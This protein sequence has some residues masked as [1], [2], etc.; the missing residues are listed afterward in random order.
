MRY[1][2]FI[3]DVICLKL[4]D[5]LRVFHRLQRSRYDLNLGDVSVTFVKRSEHR[6][7]IVDIRHGKHYHMIIRFCIV[8]TER[9][10]E[11]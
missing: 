6:R 10:T 1:S 5:K 2:R 7:E 4:D 11:L 9:S 8:N 3:S